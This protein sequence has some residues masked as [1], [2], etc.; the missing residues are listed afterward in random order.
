MSPSP[1]EN[2]RIILVE[3]R[4]SANVGS[5]ARAMKNFGLSDLCLVKPI[6]KIDEQ[7]RNMASK[8]QDVLGQ[9]AHHSS[10]ESAIGDCRYVVGF[11]AS[12]EK[13]CL[14][15]LEFDAAMQMV[16]QDAAHGR[17]GFLFGRE[18]WGLDHVALDRCRYV[19]Q[20]PTNPLYS[21]LNLAQAVLVVGYSL[22][23]LAHQAPV[24]KATENI[25]E[26]WFEAPVQYQV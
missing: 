3:P 26:D 25:S 24:M 8:A 13:G 21:S 7:A 17:I 22:F 10:L 12:D 14:T 16:F 5:T 18:D 1:F 6:A 19:T 9:A 2:I 11:T 4:G 20:I 15:R 23:R